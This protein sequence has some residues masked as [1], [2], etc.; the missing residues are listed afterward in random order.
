MRAIA[1]SDNNSDFPAVDP[2]RQPALSMGHD[3]FASDD[4]IK[5]GL[6]QIVMCDQLRVLFST[7]FIDSFAA[8]LPVFLRVAQLHGWQNGGR[9]MALGAWLE[10]DFQ[11][12]RPPY[13]SVWDIGC[14]ED[15]TSPHRRRVNQTEGR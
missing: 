14:M 7:P 6:L 11:G 15:A 10:S 9:M 13:A 4:N 12:H 3:V 1:P 8:E 5:G 2:N